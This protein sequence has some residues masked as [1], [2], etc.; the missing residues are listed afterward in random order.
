MNFYS[1]RTTALLC[2][3]V[4]LFYRGKAIKFGRLSIRG[5]KNANPSLSMRRWGY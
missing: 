4:I 2:F 1:F 5:E 3:A